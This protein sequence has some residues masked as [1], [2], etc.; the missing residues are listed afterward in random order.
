MYW[1]SSLEKRFFF[2]F[3]PNDFQT[4]VLVSAW[5]SMARTLIT[6]KQ[7]QAC[8]FAEMSVNYFCKSSYLGAEQN[9]YYR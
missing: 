1:H 3:P 4:D 8:L 5:Y 9:F 7:Q 2:N 6:N